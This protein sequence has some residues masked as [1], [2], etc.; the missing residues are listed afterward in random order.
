ME[1]DPAMG[2]GDV[3]FAVM[4]AQFAV[5]LERE[6]GVRYGNDPEDLHQMRVAIRRVRAA[7]VVF[8]EA[9]PAR[10]P[11][12]RREL[13]WLG[14]LL[15]AVRDLDVQLA[16]T[17]EWSAAADP[18]EREALD[19]MT[20]VLDNRRTKARTRLKT[21]MDSRRLI[22]LN[23][24][25]EKFLIHGPVKRSAA[26]HIPILEAAPDVVAQGYRKVVSIGDHISDSSP[27]QELHALRIRAKRLRYT[28]EFIEPIYGKP[29]R[30]YAKRLVALQDILGTH[31]DDVVAVSTLRDIAIDPPVR[32]GPPIVLVLGMLAERYRTG[33]AAARGRFPKRYRRVTGDRWRRLMRALDEQRPHEQLASAKDGNEPMVEPISIVKGP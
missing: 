31:Q 21:A 22:R 33:A 28:V 12:L 11:H 1:I 13:K 32:V 3:A 16:Q 4:R 8:E 17:G 6:P 15:G 10:A 18:A 19:L 25:M 14:S 5:V 27:A 7:M 20:A 29:A 24:S 30:A 26:A 2:V 9:L 23:G